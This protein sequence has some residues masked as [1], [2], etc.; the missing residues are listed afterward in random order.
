MFCIKNYGEYW[1]ETVALALNQVI[2]YNYIIG[3]G[4]IFG[5]LFTGVLV[6]YLLPLQKKKMK[7]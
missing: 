2:S 5:V 6:K 7:E 3:F 4:V 1:P